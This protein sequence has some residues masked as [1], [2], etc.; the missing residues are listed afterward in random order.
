MTRSWK[1]RNL[2]FFLSG[3][4]LSPLGTAAATGLLYQPQTIDYECGA[5]GGMRIDRG[6]RSTRRKPAPAPRCPQQISHNLTRVRTRVAAVGS[7]WLTAWAMARP[8]LESWSG[9]WLFWLV[10]V[11]LSWNRKHV[12]DTKNRPTRESKRFKIGEIPSTQEMRGTGHNENI[13]L[14]LRNNIISEFCQCESDYSLWMKR[15]G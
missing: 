6:N 1:P 13:F 12:K 3:V 8:S 9:V 11:S 2:P 14:N 5:V 7:R 10:V 4:R 15:G